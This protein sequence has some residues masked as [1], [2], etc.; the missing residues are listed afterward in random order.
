MLYGQSDM[1]ENSYVHKFAIAATRIFSPFEGTAV[2][3]EEMG[4]FLIASN[5]KVVI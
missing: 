1:E 5:E 3:R 4:S 2:S